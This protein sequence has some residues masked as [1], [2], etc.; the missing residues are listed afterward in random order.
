[1][2]N[3]KIENRGEHHSS[4]MFPSNLSMFWFVFSFIG[5]KKRTVFF[6]RRLFF[7]VSNAL[8]TENKN[9]FPLEHAFCFFTIKK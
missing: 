7:Y 5:K 2:Y 9:K 8:G 6:E 3:L 1:H 4:M